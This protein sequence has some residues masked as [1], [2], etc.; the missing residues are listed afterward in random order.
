[1]TGGDWDGARGLGLD[2]EGIR[3]GEGQKE[4][5]PKPRRG[6]LEMGSARVLK[7]EGKTM[8]GAWAM[9]VAAAGRTRARAC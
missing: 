2:W 1:M 9:G 3:A 4:E 6:R 8:V 5:L 7:L